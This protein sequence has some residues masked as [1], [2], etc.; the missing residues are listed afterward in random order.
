MRKRVAFLAL[1]LALIITLI[2]V[3]SFAAEG[4][5][6]KDS[7]GWWFRNDD[8]SYPS[9]Q[10]SLI[11]DRWYFFND[12]G[13]MCRGWLKYRDTW[14]YLGYQFDSD[15]GAMRTGWVKDSGAW[16]YMDS[17][18]AMET[19]WI[20]DGNRWYY[21]L[22][23]GEM[24]TYWYHIG[25]NWYYFG[26]DGAMKRG[27]QYIGDAWY[28]LG[29]EGDPDTGAMRTGW[30][31]YR[32]EWYYLQVNG[33]MATGRINLNQG[34][35]KVPDYNYFDDNGVW[36]EDTDGAQGYA[37]SFL[38]K[39]WTDIGGD[40]AL[41]VFDG[42]GYYEALPGLPYGV[43]TGYTGWAMNNVYG[44]SDYPHEISTADNRNAGEFV[45]AHRMWLLDN[46]EYI[47]SATTEDGGVTYH[48]GR[49]MPG[50]III[51]NYR[52]DGEYGELRLT[53]NSRYCDC[54]HDGNEAVFTHVGIVGADTTLYSEDLQA[55]KFWKTE[56]ELPEGQYNMHHSTGSLRGIRNI[57][58]PE[59]F[60]TRDVPD[61]ND[62]DYS[63]SYEI[64][65]VLKAEPVEIDTDTED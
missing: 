53:R 33:A 40:E 13:Y 5:W 26:S 45:D 61:E 20:K 47:G 41:S 55:G 32:D 24:A 42:Q 10:W 50:D 3:K 34:I 12:Y 22:G 35:P 56:E 46:A 38:D 16:Y 39:T 29:W 15:T 62:T 7:D 1:L 54:W 48:D 37:E 64:Y 58:S 57:L 14:Y 25:S 60:I 28:Y 9:G 65:R 17:S 36:Q 8:G 27:W 18:G 59:Q 63:R 44:I 4:G 11:N 49:Y 30:I 43:C 19:G 6:H 51:F 21:L 31:N 23:S 2:P 52:R